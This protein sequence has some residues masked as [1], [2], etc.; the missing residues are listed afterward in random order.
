MSLRRFASNALRALLMSTAGAAFIGSATGASV[1]ARLVAVEADAESAKYTVGP[2]STF[3]LQDIPNDVRLVQVEDTLGQPNGTAS[4]ELRVD[5]EQTEFTAAMNSIIN[6]AVSRGQVL[7]DAQADMRAAQA[8]WRKQDANGRWWV[9]CEKDFTL[10][11]AGCP[12]DGNMSSLNVVTGTLVTQTVQTWINYHI[13]L[14]KTRM[15]ASGRHRVGPL[16]F[17][18][19][20]NFNSFSIDGGGTNFDGGANFGGLTFIQDDWRQPIMFIS[21]GRKV[22]SSHLSLIGP[23]ARHMNTNLLGFTASAPGALDDMV[24]SNWNMPS[25]P[26]TQNNRYNPHGL[27]AIDA[28]CGTRPT[29]V[30]RANAT[31]YVYRDTFHAGGNVYFCERAGTTGTG[32]A[33]TGTDPTALYTDGTATFRWLGAYDAG[34]PHQW[35]SY[36][37]MPIVGNRWCTGPNQYGRNNYSSDTTFNH[38]MFRGGTYGA[39]STPSNNSLQNDFCRFNNCTFIYNRFSDTSGNDQDRNRMHNGCDFALYHTA[40]SNSQIGTQRGAQQLVSL[41]CS[42]GAGIYIHDLEMGYGGSATFINGYCEAQ[43][44][45]FLLQQTN[46]GDTGLRYINCKWDFGSNPARGRVGRTM[47]L[48]SFPTNVTTVGTS[49]DIRFQGGIVSFYGALSVF[50]DGVSFDGTLL[51]DFDTGAITVPLWQAQALQA[52]SG[53]LFMPSLNY[54]RHGNQ[55]M[56]FPLHNVATGVAPGIAAHVQDAYIHS[57]RTYTIPLA[58]RSVRPVSSTVEELLAVPHDSGS[59]TTFAINGTTVTATNGPNPCEISVFVQGA[60]KTGTCDRQGFGPGGLAIH[61][62]TGTCFFI[63]S[64][65]DTTDTAILVPLDNFRVV[66]AVRQWVNAPQLANGEQF[67]F[68]RSNLYTPARPVFFDCAAASGNMTNMG[69]SAG[70]G[71]NLATDMTN[72]DYIVTSSELDAMFGAVHTATIGTITNGSPGSAVASNNFATGKGATHRRLPFLRIPAA[73]NA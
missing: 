17:G 18:W 5:S 4:F 51:Y 19:G 21:G 32:T 59:V 7:A 42:Y 63:R 69:N 11:M 49:R 58:V 46:S 2:W 20:D 12:G 29:P 71:T 27:M 33:P 34:T 1:E 47:S 45:L 48:R 44:R 37:D 25:L 66:S 57:D 22:S 14:K 50:V 53:G 28:F 64:F 16:Y 55:G 39:M 9:E 38:C 43:R 30:A 36:P 40:H 73:P 41:G 70:V 56:R 62:Q 72:G 52:S 6:F 54:W 13:F 3:H 67:M 68:R 23:Y 26:T 60:S 31:A 15:I 65:N 10:A 35:T 24:D 61:I 8:M